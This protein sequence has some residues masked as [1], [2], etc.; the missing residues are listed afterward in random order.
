MFNPPHPGEILKTGYLEELNI[1]IAKFALMIG[2]SRKTVYDIVNCKSSITPKMALKLEK[3]FNSDASFWLDLQ[4]KYDLWE[5]QQ[6]TNLDNIQAV[7]G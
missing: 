1:S 7:W 3:V 2:V 5:A 4:M 6:E